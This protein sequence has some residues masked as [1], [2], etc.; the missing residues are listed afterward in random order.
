MTGPVHTS[1]GWRRFRRQASSKLADMYEAESK[2]AAQALNA[3]YSADDV[4]RNLDLDFAPASITAVVGANGA[5]KSALLK[6][7]AR[8][9]K[10]SGGS[11]LLDGVSITS[12][13]K[14]EV[15]GAIGFLG[16]IP[17]TRNS[18]SVYDL[19]SRSAMLA[20]QIS[21]VSPRLKTQID[22]ILTRTGLE[23]L[24]K[25]K[26]GELSSGWRQVAVIA[27]ALV[28]EPQVLLLDEPTSSLDYSHQLQVI[29]LLS[30]LKREKGMT[31]I[32]VI[33]DLNLAARFADWVVVLKHGKVISQGTP[34]EVITP[35]TLADGFNILA[36][37]IED[38]V[39][40]TPVVV[41]IRQLGD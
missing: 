23:A 38:P 6:A 32:T 11:V 5:G 4:I 10:V 39:A 41:P 27:A 16:T 29:N 40:K 13:S 25:K 33:H 35:T 26:I 28:K 9:I 8:K 36:R 31:I 22:E 2:L 3:G 15:E 20:N 18:E 37:V 7:L 12:L 34:K 21:R 14:A 24:K 30:S 17:A 1:A 19:V